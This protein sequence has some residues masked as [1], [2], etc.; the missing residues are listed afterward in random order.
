MCRYVRPDDDR[1][2]VVEPDDLNQ[3]RC[4]AKQFDIGEQ[5]PVD[6]GPAP[7]AKDADDQTEHCSEKDGTDRVDDGPAEPEPEQMAV[8]AEDREIPNVVHASPRLLF[9]HDLL[10]NAVPT[11]PD[12]A[13]PRASPLPFVGHQR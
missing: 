2:G 3:Q 10:G 11:F 7:Q 12:H 6:H 5:K 1:Q 13:L 8:F 4:A 9:E